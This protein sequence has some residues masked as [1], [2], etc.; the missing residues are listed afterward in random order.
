VSRNI[1]LDNHSIEDLMQNMQLTILIILS[2]MLIVNLASAADLSRLYQDLNNSSVDIRA[3]A[4]KSL[5]YSNETEA[6]DLLEQSLSD[7]SWIVRMQTASALGHSNDSRA[8]QPLIQL[9]KDPDCDVQIEAII[10]LVNIGD[11][12]AEETLILLLNDTNHMVS[13]YAAWALGKMNS[14]KAVDYLILRLQSNNSNIRAM[15]AKSLR[16]VNSSKATEPL[17]LALKDNNTNVRANAALALGGIKYSAAAAPL[18]VILEEN[19]SITISA[20]AWALGELKEKKAVESLVRLLENRAW[21][22]RSAAAEALGKINDSRSV[23]PLIVALNDEDSIVRMKATRS[24][25]ITKNSS[26]IKPLEAATRDADE[27]VRASAASALMK[28]NM[29]AAIKAMA[30]SLLYGTQG[31][32]SLPPGDVFAPMYAK[33]IIIRADDIADKNPFVAY[34]SNLTL[35]KGF[36]TTYAVIPLRLERLSNANNDNITYLKKLDKEHFEL[37]AHGYDHASFEERPYPE[38]RE[39]VNNAT[40]LMQKM[41]GERPTT[42]VPPFHLCDLN[43]TKACSAEG[44]HSLSSGHIPNQAYIKNFGAGFMWETDWDARPVTIS[45][46]RNFLESYEQ[47]NAT[48]SE[49]LVMLLHPTAIFKNESG[50]FNRKNMELFERCIDYMISKGA[51]F[52][53]VEEAYQWSVDENAIRLGKVSPGIYV[54]DMTSCCFNHTIRLSLPL[55]H[56]TEISCEESMPLTSKWSFEALRGKRYE[57]CLADNKTD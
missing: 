21:F 43:T 27:G 25:E 57:I 14:S 45:S 53:T 40:I 20:A 18:L 6:F 16:L 9:L 46:F 29:S 44:Y 51:Q 47:F 30:S 48:S 13:D 32:A 31:P 17:L 15:A 7:E 3:N 52:Q 11:P 19:D 55:D 5:E 28:I 22:V 42:F 50:G 38:Q 33:K 12:K 56:V 41:F 24:L 35:Q 26:T 4:V 1:Y 10:A 37:A 8:V 34:L 36:K 2:A 54:A 39:M 23:A 49:F